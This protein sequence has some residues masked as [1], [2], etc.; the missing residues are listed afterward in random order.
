M[1]NEHQ[2]TVVVGVDGSPTSRMALRWGL[3]HAGLAGGAL[4]AVMAWDMP[5]RYGW[6]GPGLD[7]FE[8]DAARALDEVVDKVGTVAGTVPVT[9]RIGQGHPA[10]VIIEVAGK[11]GADLVVVGNRGHGGFTEAMLGSTGQYTVHHAHCPVVVVR[12]STI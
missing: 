7:E 10:K 5:L 11:V 3:W 4:T 9:K 2:Y 6:S 1:T 8:D 12:E